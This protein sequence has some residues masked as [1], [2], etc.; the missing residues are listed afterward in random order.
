MKKRRILISVI[1]V[2]VLA[3]VTSLA[4]YKFLDTNKNKSP[5]I[6]TATEAEIMDIY[7]DM[8]IEH[9]KFA[10]TIFTDTS[11]IMEGTGYFGKGGGQKI[12]THNNYTLYYAF[13]YTQ[14]HGTKYMPEEDQENT[15]YAIKDKEA[16]EEVKQKAL[17][18][19][20]YG[21]YTHNSVKK[22]QTIEAMKPTQAS[23]GPNHWQSS[24]YANGVLW[25]A[26]WWDHPDEPLKADVGQLLFTEEQGN[27]DNPEA[28]LQETQELK[29]MPGI[30]T[31]HP[32]HTACFL[33]TRM[34]RNGR[35]GNQV[36]DEH[37]V[38]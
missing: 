16:F 9:K 24:L 21:I 36:C 22:M 12:R 13:L 35:S 8:L 17:A 29:R 23:G 38:S 7:L 1:I 33:N 26:C 28:M 31:D 2:A 32:L 6:I 34:R 3:A 14:L 19:I 10:D 15:E 4:L 20:R 5:G 11:N 37:L 27:K 30:P 18:G 25:A